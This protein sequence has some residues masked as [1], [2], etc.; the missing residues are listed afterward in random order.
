[1]SSWKSY[2]F[3]AKYFCFNFVISM[4]VFWKE[5]KIIVNY[6]QKFPIYN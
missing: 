3:S 6:I 2:S 5:E 4:Y 1:M